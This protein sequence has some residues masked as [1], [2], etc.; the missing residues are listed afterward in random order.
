M[1][2][3]CCPPRLSTLLLLFPWIPLPPNSST[4]SPRL[5]IDGILVSG[6]CSCI[7]RE[8][9]FLERVASGVP[10][11]WR[12]VEI[13]ERFGSCL[14]KVS[15][16]Q[17]AS[18]YRNKAGTLIWESDEALLQLHLDYLLW[19]HTRKNQ[20]A[21]TKTSWA[22]LPPQASAAPRPSLLTWAMTLNEPSP[23]IWLVSGVW[24]MLTLDWKV[25]CACDSRHRWC[26]TES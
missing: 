12:N 6:K 8:T 17:G 25:L 11:Y 2:N 19:Q 7:Q 10:R 3:G 24:S 18:G 21:Q 20:W 5:L 1:T 9:A 16:L 13:W 4:L 14:L 26:N 15:K 23:G 22:L